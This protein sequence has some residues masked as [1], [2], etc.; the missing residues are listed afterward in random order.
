ML[1]PLFPNTFLLNVLLIF[2]PFLWTSGDRERKYHSQAITLIRQMLLFG[3]AACGIS[4]QWVQ[5]KIRKKYLQKEQQSQLKSFK[6]LFSSR[7]KGFQIQYLYDDT[8]SPS[9]RSIYFASTQL[10]TGFS[11]FRAICF[12]SE[13]KLEIEHLIEIHK[14]VALFAFRAQ[15]NIIIRF[16]HT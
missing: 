15:N 13:F 14:Q 1:K 2:F 7:K 8:L 3:F 16:A 4:G 9:F 5:N 11:F 6:S 10:A 12:V